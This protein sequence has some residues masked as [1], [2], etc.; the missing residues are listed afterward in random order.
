[1]RFIRKLQIEIADQNVK[2]ALGKT[3]FFTIYSKGT[4]IKREI[5]N[6]Q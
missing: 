1:M 5:Q 2:I 3:I 4:Q 6:S